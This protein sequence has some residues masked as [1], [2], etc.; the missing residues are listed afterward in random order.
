LRYGGG[1]DARL[2]SVTDSVR[3]GL[4]L[5]FVDQGPGIGDIELALKDGYTTGNGLGLGLGGSKRLCDEFTIVSEP[6][7]GTT[8]CIT[9]WK[10]R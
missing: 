9:K 2:E 8:I 6:G 10:C 4:T 7:H 3:T 5:A 1:G